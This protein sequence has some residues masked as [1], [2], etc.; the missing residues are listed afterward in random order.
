MAKKKLISKVVDEIEHIIAGEPEKAAEV[1]ETA[2]KDPMY[3]KVRIT[4]PVHLKIKRRV[5]NPGTHIV[6]RHQV[7][8]ILEMV[9][10]K[11]KANLAIFTGNNYL[12]EKMVDGALKVT[13]VEELDMNRIVKG[14]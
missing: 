12:V 13:Q 9:H 10:K 7:E 3:D 5:L 14:R 8:T 4:I 2:E 6:E 11:Q 1:V